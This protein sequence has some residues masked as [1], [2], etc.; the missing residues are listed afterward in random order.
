MF[1]LLSGI[2]CAFAIP[3]KPIPCGN[4]VTVNGQVT[5]KSKALA[6]GA[7]IYP[8]DE[9][10][11]GENSSAKFLMVDKSI[12]DLGASTSFKFDDYRDGEGDSRQADL[13]LNLGTVRA[14]VTKKLDEKSKFYIRTKSSVLAV[15]GTEFLAKHEVK[16]GKVT[17]QVTV[18]SGKVEMNIAGKV[19]AFPQD[20][21]Q[22]Y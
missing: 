21:T 11:T 7:P 13:T 1:L 12:I 16:D 18:G 9:V 10:L 22:T 15:R 5:I 8:D 3:K 20:M 19:V 6:S 14:S 2:P 4:V 17:E